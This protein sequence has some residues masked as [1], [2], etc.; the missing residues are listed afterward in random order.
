MR[1]TIKEA[2]EINLPSNGAL[3]TWLRRERIS[4]RMAQNV[5]YNDKYYRVNAR[6]YNVDL[7][8]LYGDE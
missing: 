2:K 3:H 8:F 1:Y 7:A 5:I 6:P 4:H